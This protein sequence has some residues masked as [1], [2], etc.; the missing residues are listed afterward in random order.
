[1]FRGW[2]EKNKFCVHCGTYLTF[3][4]YS[5]EETDQALAALEFDDYED[6]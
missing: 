3:P 6:T 4:N 1:M 5:K 2:E